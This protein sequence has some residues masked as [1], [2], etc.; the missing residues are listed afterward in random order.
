[1][2]GCHPERSEGPR[3]VPKERTVIPS[4]QARDRDRPKRG[5]AR[6]PG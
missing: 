1:M 3:V 2:F 6:R 4:R 5:L